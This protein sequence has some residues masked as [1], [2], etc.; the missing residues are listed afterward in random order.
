MKQFKKIIIKDEVEE[1]SNRDY[2]GSDCGGGCENG[3]YNNDDYIHN[4]NL[5]IIILK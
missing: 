2:C 4:D 5:Y 1:D 3:G